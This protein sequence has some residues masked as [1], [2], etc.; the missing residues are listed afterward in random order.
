[1]FVVQAGQKLLDIGKELLELS[2]SV[3]GALLE[4]VSN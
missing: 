2:G 3:Q 1:M 4:R